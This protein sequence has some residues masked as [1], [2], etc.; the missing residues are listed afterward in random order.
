MLVELLP[1]DSNATLTSFPTSPMCGSGDGGL[2]PTAGCSSQLYAMMGDCTGE[3]KCL[4]GVASQPMADHAAR[5]CMLLLAWGLGL[6]RCPQILS[7]ILEIHGYCSSHVA[8][9][10]TRE[11]G[12]LACRFIVDR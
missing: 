2:C 5:S 4:F 8:L 12:A 10:R 6:S 1:G 9:G 11:G 7:C 3:D